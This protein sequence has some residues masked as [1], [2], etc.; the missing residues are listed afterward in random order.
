MTTLSTPPYEEFK[1]G[2]DATISKL[3]SKLQAVLDGAQN[4]ERP[5]I[6]AINIHL[7]GVE[8]DLLRKQ[9]NTLGSTYSQLRET[10]AELMMQRDAITAQFNLIK[11]VLREFDEKEQGNN[12]E[13]AQPQNKGKPRKSKK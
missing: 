7:L 3:R 12:Q 2:I 8:I 11:S 13:Q 5:M 10:N 9:I 4:G 1:A 6:Q